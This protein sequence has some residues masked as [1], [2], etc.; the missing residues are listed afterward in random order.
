MKKATRFIGLDV[1]ADTIAVAIAEPG[2]AGEVRS[3]GMIPNRPE[4]V[5]KLVQRLGG[6]KAIQVCYEAGPTGYT[7]YWQLTE[8]GVECEVVAPTLFQR[9]LAIESR[10]IDAT[11]SSWRAAS[12]LASSRRS[13]FQTRRTKP[14]AIWFVHEKRPR[15]IS[16][17]RGIG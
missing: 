1:H 15:R 6:A 9:R 3:F 5:R 8:M 10:R 11:R 16:C 17:E 13:G 14:C 7:L 2:R 4:A 12:A